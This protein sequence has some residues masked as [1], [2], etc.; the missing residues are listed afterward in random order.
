M[1]THPPSYRSNPSCDCFRS[2]KNCANATID[3]NANSAGN[4]S[5]SA[6]IRAPAEPKPLVALEV[7]TMR[8]TMIRV[9]TRVVAVVALATLIELVVAHALG[10]AGVIVVRLVLCVPFAAIA[11]ATGK[12]GKDDGSRHANL[13]I[14][15]TMPN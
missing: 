3:T 15:A 8:R 11:P 4:A 5:R 2:S 6:R 1:A 14:H 13:E 10:A 7:P 9:A 12:T